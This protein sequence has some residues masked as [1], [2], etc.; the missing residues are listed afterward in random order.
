MIITKIRRV[1]G[2]KPRY[3]I[4]FDDAPALEVSDWTVGRFGLCTGDE[5][6]D[7]KRFQIATAEAE[8]Q[9][10]NI[11]INF[12]SYR[13]RSRKEIEMHLMKKGFDE[14]IAGQA[15]D[16]L[17]SLSMVND[18]EFARMFVRDRLQR[19]KIGTSLLRQQLIQ[20]GIARTI[21]DTICSE[22]VTPDQQK[23]AAFEAAEKYQ[24]RSH[25]AKRKKMFSP[26][27]VQK[28][29]KRLF[30]FLIRRGFSIDL[31]RQTVETFFRKN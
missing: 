15:A 21:I 31:T 13:P 25:E 18:L 4:E 8:A 2:R 30:D 1:R 26:I 3:M 23:H 22:L 11:A 19:K 29:K 27:E 28:H 5:I 17:Q 9:A 20:K 7:L 14:A 6:D 16:K 10:K 24:Q 12:L